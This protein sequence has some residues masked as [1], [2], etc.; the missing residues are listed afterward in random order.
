[1]VEFQL[2]VSAVGGGAPYLAHHVKRVSGL[3]ETALDVQACSP[4]T[5]DGC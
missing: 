1:M 4:F 2:G 3:V 5:A